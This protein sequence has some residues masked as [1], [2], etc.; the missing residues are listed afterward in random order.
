MTPPVRPE[1]ER[2]AHDRRATLALSLVPDVGRVTYRALVEQHGSPARALAAS[3]S[4]SVAADAYAAADR[5]VARGETFGLALVLEHDDDYPAALR[6]LPS[7]PITLWRRG[8]WSVAA[9]P[10]VA[11][12]GTR[13][14][15]AY[16]ERIARELGGALARAGACIVSGMAAGIDATVHRAALDANGRTVAVLGTGADV[17]Y[18]RAHTALHREIA[19]KGMLLS[20]LPPGAH[21][22][23]GSF[24][25]RNRIIAAL[26]RLTIVVEAPF[27]SGALITLD[28]AADL[29]RDVAVV[30]GPI[31]VP[32]CAGSNERLRDGAQA[33][34]SVAD[35]LSLAGLTAPV[36]SH[37]TFT[38]DA[39][40]EV[41]SALQRG[42]ATL[43]DLCAR[44]ELPVARCL[45]AVTGLEV[46]GLVECALTGEIRRR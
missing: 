23:G 21:S 38:D 10:V 43:D 29:G 41:W 26:A 16:G 19:E 9:P 15:T 12:V 27:R 8:D 32:Q 28:R 17:V 5:A 46:R 33:I 37:P 31:D 25:D 20:E 4:A 39:E 34:V 35:A 45:S 44:A 6:D 13:R 22:N 42:A 3:L 1:G 24:P 30:P 7:P 18:P 2:D 40:R 14:A 36:R 11:I